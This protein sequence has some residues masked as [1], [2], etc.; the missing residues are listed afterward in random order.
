MSS[1]RSVAASVASE[2]NALLDESGR[3]L[4]AKYLEKAMSKV[5]ST[6]PNK[7]NGGVRVRKPA[8][9]PGIDSFVIFSHDF[10]YKL[11][12]FHTEH[13]IHE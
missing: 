6:E 9:H 12:S 13:P 11:D 10:C 1:Q 7:T 3:I 8:S 5:S 4:T 2:R